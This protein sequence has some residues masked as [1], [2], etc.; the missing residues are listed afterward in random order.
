M[1]RAMRCVD[2]EYW[3]P[4]ALIALL[5]LIG[6]FQI[7][8]R[9]IFSYPLTWA[10]EAMRLSFLLLVFFGAFAV[11]KN[12][13]HLL[14]DLLSMYGRPKM[15]VRSWNAYEAVVLIVQAAFFALCAYGSFQ[16]AAVRWNIV[17]QTMP[18]WRIGFMYV[19]T[20]SA[21]LA[22]SLASV[23]LIFQNDPAEKAGS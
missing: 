18:F 9:F 7:F 20:G 8:S 2:Y 13:G 5:F 15:S 21:F 14:V 22:C 16:M 17:S 19:L 1:K 10:E 4:G 12:R 11:T 3:V 23:Y 6:C